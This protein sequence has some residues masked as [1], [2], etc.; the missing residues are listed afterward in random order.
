MFIHLQHINSKYLCLSTDTTRIWDSPYSGQIRLQGG[1]YSSY[2][3]LEVYC[4][5]QWGTVCDDSFGSTA[6]RV[7]CRQLGYSNYSTYKGN[8]L[9]KLIKN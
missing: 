4:N 5:G 3:R 7:A 9:V 8:L 1:T 6:A 2:G